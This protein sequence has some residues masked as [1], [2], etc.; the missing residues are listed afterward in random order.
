MTEPDGCML[1][2]LKQTHVFPDGWIID[3][4][5][6]NYLKSE[7]RTVQ[8]SRFVECSLRRVRFHLVD[9]VF[10]AFEI[11]VRGRCSCTAVGLG[12]D[13]TFGAEGRVLYIGV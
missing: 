13:A 2:D 8:R 4:Y 5:K 1:Q 3:L 11:A 7:N 6:E 12:G 10:Q 9:G